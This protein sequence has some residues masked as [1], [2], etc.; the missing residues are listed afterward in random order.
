[1]TTRITPEREQTPSGAVQPSPQSGPPAGRPPVRAWLQ[2][3]L[4]ALIVVAAFLGSYIGL[5]RDPQP[6]QVPIAV[7]G[8]ELPG[9]VSEALGDAVEVRPVADTE[10]ARQALERHDV[11]AVLSANGPDRLRLDIAGAAGP[12][13]TS[14]VSDLVGA[15]AHGSG[16]DVTTRDVVPLTHFD[17]R[18][19]AGF[20]VA[21]G[22][23][24]A[25][26]VL[27]SNVLGLATSMRLRHRFV[28]LL[29]A[30]VAIGAVAAVIAGPVLGAV[31]APIV[32][33]ILT[34][35]LLSAAAAFT[36]TLLGTFLGPVGLPL[37]TLVLLTVGNATSGAIIGAD[38]LPAG[39]RAVSSLLPPGAAVRAIADLSYYHGAHTAVPLVTLA[40]WAAI[41]A[42]LLS[43]RPRFLQRRKVS[44]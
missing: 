36:T 6:H 39:A 26:F 7:T 12:S 5:Q 8:P 15:Y 22:V 31:P 16:M 20:Y 43:L 38:L 13:T 3:T 1:M 32:P 27:G 4:I 42:I 21:F 19:L 41:G 10:A 23:T 33:L 29:G 9:R 11:V 28:L 40:L 24:L 44:A 25:G 34:L 37:T 30:S 18:G 14:A 17:A 2:P 35:T